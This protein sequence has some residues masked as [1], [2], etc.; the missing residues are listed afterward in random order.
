MAASPAAI[1]PGYLVLIRFAGEEIIADRAENVNQ[2]TGLAAN[3]TVF[4]IGRN[5]E[6]IPG[7]ESR[8]DTIDVNIE[9]AT[10]NITDLG[11]NVC[12][13]RTNGPDFE[14]DPGHQYRIIVTEQLPGQAFSN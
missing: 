9:L 13:S 11:V 2:H 1:H 4:E 5:I 7:A 8:F 14:I 10:H 3:R 6:T 12:M